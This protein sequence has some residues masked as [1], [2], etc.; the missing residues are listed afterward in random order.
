MPEN[1]EKIKELMTK[2]L[3]LQNELN[4]MRSNYFSV[5]SENTQL[6]ARLFKNN[7]PVNRESFIVTD[8]N[9]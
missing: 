6:K 2:I 9:G 5:Q 7:L 3:E 4:Q 8:T 1:K